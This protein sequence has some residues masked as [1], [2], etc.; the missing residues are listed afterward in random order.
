MDYIEEHGLE[1]NI[2]HPQVYGDYLIWRLW[3]GHRSFFDSQVHLFN[4]SLFLD[5]GLI[6]LDPHWQER[7][8]RYDIALLLLRKNAEDNQMMIQDAGKSADWRTL[9]EDDLSILFQRVR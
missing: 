3:P 4:E 9:Y 5:Y 1:G 7:L 2:F 6:F 8:G